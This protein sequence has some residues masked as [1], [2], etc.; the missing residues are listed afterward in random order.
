M[1]VSR[2]IFVVLVNIVIAD[3]VS[4]EQFTSALGLT[5]FISGN[6]IL[7]MAPAIG[8]KYCNKD[9]IKFMPP[10]SL[11][12][13]KNLMYKPSKLLM[14]WNLTKVLHDLQQRAALL[15]NKL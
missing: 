6:M 4:P 11:S 12:V 1:G 10:T 13:T 2:G 5:L 9:I 7:I 8:E 14:S 15:K 3:A